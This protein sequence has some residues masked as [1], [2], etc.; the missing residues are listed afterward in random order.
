MPIHRPLMN[1]PLT[2]ILTACATS[3]TISADDT[4][5][6]NPLEGT[7]WQL[8]QIQ[9][10]D[11]QVFTPDLQEKYT[12]QFEADRVALRADCNRGTGEYTFT[13]PSG[14]EFGQLA[15]TRALC[16]PDSL[17]QRYLSDLSFVRSFVLEDGNLFLAT[18]ADGAILEFA[19]LQE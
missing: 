13:P 7:G 8:V 11:D 4:A 17:D 6:A 14:L 1:L 19:P 10:M 3:G 18:M 2:L 12:L 16:P 9:S 5:A 15:T